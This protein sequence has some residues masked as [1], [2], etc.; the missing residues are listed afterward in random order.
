MK[1]KILI[2]AVATLLFVLSGCDASDSSPASFTRTE[3]ALGTFVTVRIDG[4]SGKDANQA[5]DGTFARL[6]EIELTASTKNHGSELSYVNQNA[7]ERGITVSEELFFLLE[8]GL[9]YS[10]LTDGAFDI[11]LG[12]VVE[13]WGI[14]TD[15]A[16]VP[17]PDELAEALENSGFENLL[18]SAENRT[19]R[20]LKEGL[21]IDLGALAK[22]YAADEMK[23]VLLENGVTSAVLNLGG[24][25]ITIGDKNGEDWLI[26]LA[27]PLAPGESCAILR[28]SGLAV[29]TSG[30]YER[31]FMHEGARYHHVFDSQT[32][33]PAESGVVSSTIITDSAMIA[34]ALST[35]FFVMGIERAVEFAVSIPDTD[36]VLIDGGMNFMCSENINLEI[37]K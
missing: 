35:A 5:L 23:R 33:F 26:G 7:Y 12:S 4:T 30:N 8:S 20:F 14:G 28:V 11:T 18:L 9:F 1:V 17:A 6:S 2:L 27:D 3:F 22:G 25:I 37:I 19:V 34:D 36:Y 21:K 16:R 29:V 10:A 13:L 31:Y 32:G 24:D 15:N